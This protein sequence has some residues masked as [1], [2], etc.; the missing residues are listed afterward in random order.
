MDSTH[1]GPKSMSDFFSSVVDR[2][3]GTP[4]PA[5]VVDTRAQN[6]AQKKMNIRAV[7]VREGFA[8]MRAR[9]DEMASRLAEFK[10][11]RQHSESSTSEAIDPVEQVETIVLASTP[12]RRADGA[13]H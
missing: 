2:M 9:S 1:R 3:L 5:P 12:L 11:Q 7:G 8:A 6:L 13:A 10:K 4:A